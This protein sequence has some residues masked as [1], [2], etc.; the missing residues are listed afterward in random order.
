MPDEDSEVK[1]YL[2]SLMDHSEDCAV[3]ECHDCRTL[4]LLLF[5]LRKVIFYERVAKVK[6]EVGRAAA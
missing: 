6:S 3:D 4:R 2:Q 1:A 5:A